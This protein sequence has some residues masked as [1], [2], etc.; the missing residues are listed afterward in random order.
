MNLNINTKYNIGDTVWFADYI[1]DTH[2]PSKYSGTVREIEI[3]ISET[4]QL[5]SYWVIVDYN[6]NKELEQYSER[7]CFATYEE[8]IK[9]CKEHN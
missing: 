4:Q 6:G 9:W 1:Y 3:E 5:I 7:A 2:Y 8:C